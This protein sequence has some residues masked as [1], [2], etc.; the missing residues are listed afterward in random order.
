[1]LAVPA[2]ALAVV[3]QTSTAAGGAPSAAGDGGPGVAAVT[4]H[5][6]SNGWHTGIIVARR[7]L[8]E[9]VLPE[10]GDFPDAPYLEFGW[11][12]A[13]YF[14]NP[15]AGIG[16][17]LRAALTPTPA[18]VHLVGLPAHPRRVFPKAEIV[19]LRLTPAGF[20]ALV[21]Y[22]HASFVRDQAGQAGPAIDGL[23]AFSRFYPATGEFH[24]FNTCNTWTARGLEAAGLKVAVSGT[25][26]A[27][28]LMRQLR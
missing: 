16:L 25:L 7:D 5:V 15:D 6:A 3:L 12:D 28:D 23:Y 19:D 18:V 17:A 4:I 1:M 9:G 11:G 21:D 14:P 13:E 20:R 22:L 8:P 27:E 24:L 2:I 26:R 10:A